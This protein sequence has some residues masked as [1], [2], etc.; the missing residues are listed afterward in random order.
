MSCTFRRLIVAGFLWQVAVAAAQAQ[1][2]PEVVWLG[3]EGELSSDALDSTSWSPQLVPD[4]TT[5]ALL[6]GGGNFNKVLN[7]GSNNVTWYRMHLN[8]NGPVTVNGTGTITL[9]IPSDVSG[10][11]DP[12]NGGQIDPFDPFIDEW[13]V[14]ANGGD[15]FG[16]PSVPSVINPNIVTQSYIEANGSHSLTFNGDVEALTV[17][18]YAGTRVVFNGNVTLTAGPAPD[19]RFITGNDTLPIVTF[20]AGVALFPQD[21]SGG[22]G[23]GIRNQMTVNL[24]PNAALSSDIDTEGWGEINL[25]NGSVLR[26]FGDNKLGGSNDV[27]SRGANS[28]LTNKLDL[29]GHSDSV[30][31]LGTAGDATLVLDYGAAAGANSLHWDA[32]HQMNGQYGIVNFQ[33]GTDT[34]ELGAPGNGFW[35]ETGDPTGEAVRL[36]QIKIDGLSFAPFNPATTTPYWT[37]VDPAA[38]RAVQFFNATPNANFDGVGAVSGADFLIW[39]R[40]FGL[41]GQTTNANGDAD[42][43]GTVNAA[44]LAVFKA[45]FG[46][47]PTV[48]AAVPEPA[49][50]SMALASVSGAGL[51]LRRRGA[52]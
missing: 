44:D 16:G 24:G 51:A 29:N 30:E 20:N 8:N 25:Y 17:Q 2:P 9:A 5:G 27:W 34:L 45:Q 42:K 32:T 13:G 33:I 21:G 50:L 23:F 46:T 11:G 37:V 36:S 6:T 15:A 47:T 14:Y 19:A 1:A 49:T 22:T 7:L 12:L 40:G 52:R 48:A 38:S 4:A 43:N 41:T 28:I 18:A 39:Q 31:F 10:N 35:F 3:H 26:L